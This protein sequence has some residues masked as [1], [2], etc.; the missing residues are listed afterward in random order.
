M[1]DYTVG[2]TIYHLFTTRQFSDGVPTVLAGSPVLSAY[3]DDSA[4]QITAGI[5]LGVSHDSV[6]GMNLITIVATG[7]NGYETGKNYNVVITTGTVGGVSVVGEVVWSFSLGRAAAFGRLGAPA[8]ASVSADIAVIEGQTDDIGIAGAGLTG[9]GGMS[10]AMKAEVN[11]EADTALTDYDGPTNA[12]MEARTLVAASYFDP[13]ADAVANVTLVG[14][15]TTN[16]DMVGTDGALLAANVNVAAGVVESNVKQISDDGTSPP[17]L[18]L[19]FDGTTGLTGSLFPSTQG[20]IGGIAVTGSANNKAFD[21]YVLTTGTQ[22][23]NTVAAVRPLDGTK[24]EHTDDAG[25]MDLYY[26]VNIGGGTP[27]GVKITGLLNSGNDDLEVYGYDWI[28]AAWVQI[29]ELEG[30]SSTSSNGINEYDLLLEMVG[31]GSDFGKVRVR[32]TDGAFTLTSATLRIDQLLCS[33]ASAQSGYENGAIWIDTNRS[34]TNTVPGIDGKATNPVS[35]M[36]AAN[37]LS[38]LL[39][40]NR[41]EIA[42][43]SSITFAATQSGQ[44]FTGEE[45]ALALGGQDLTDSHIFGA[46]ITGIAT[47]TNSMHFVKCNVGTATLDSCHIEDSG[48]AGTITLGEAGTYILNNCHS[49]V[50]GPSTP[51]IDTGAAISNVNLAMPDYHNGI[52]L[53]NLNATG[54]DLFSISGIGQIIYAASCSGAVEQRGEWKVTN[55]GGVTITTDDDSTNIAAILDDTADM[56]PKLGSPAV[57]ISADILAID[58][59]VD[60]IESTL[61]VAGAGLTDL[62]GMSTAMKAEIQVEADASLASYDGP[63]NAE[64]VARTLAAASYF[65]PAADAVANV[66]LVATTTVNTDMVGTDNA[67]LAASA[68]TNFGDLSISITTG[69]VDITQAAADKVWSTAVRILT[70][71]TNFNDVSAAEVNAEVDTALADIDL[72]HLLKT[73]TAIPALT[74]GTFLDQMLDDGT[75]TF[76]RTTDSLQA[77]RDRG[78]NAWITA[79]GFSSHTAADVWTVATRVLTANT[80]LNDISTADVADEL[81][82]Y[83]GPTNAEM[84]AR[85]LVAASYFDPTTDAVATVT[86]LTNKT[87]FSLAATGLDAIVSTATG[88]VAI[89]KAVWDRIISKANHDIGQSAGKI[90]RLSGNIAQVDGAVSDVSPAVGGFDTNLIYP[91]TYWEDAIL[92]FSNGAA[93]AG[94]G[95]PISTFLNANGAMTFA[96]PDDW[97]V[98][99]VNGDD[100]TIYGFHVHPVA[101]IADAV[102]EAAVTGR[103]AGSLGT[104]VADTETDATAILADTADMQPKL[105]TPATDLAADVAAVK[106]DTAAIL[107]DTAEIGVAGAGLTDLGGMSTGMKAEV[108]AEVVDVMTVDTIAEP[109][110]PPAAD[111]PAFDKLAWVT[112]LARNKKNGTATLKTLR[113]DD[114]NADIATAVVSDDGTTYTEDEWV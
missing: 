34:N 51:I 81:A 40:L 92:V 2:E 15:V 14:T 76:D 3:E 95:L 35:T 44:V 91:D 90:L 111:A 41:F 68:P 12:E 18:A 112:V 52:E 54:T 43:A 28:A 30:Q 99:P 9:L 94:L 42:P 109:S 33:F 17:N 32:F 62:G 98:T 87:G 29:G 48:F 56:Q 23:A 104:A 75:A 108:N 114:D 107:V 65:D 24:H 73:A 36:D 72:D 7:A 93:N 27:S 113:N 59:F 70:A 46:D 100:F 26:E 11:A 21:S 50:A 55:T 67:L 13:A 19:Q 77:I 4:T 85:T 57:D 60:G 39:N 110:G 47:N 106:V 102:L 103:S 20:Q 37:T 89:A 16:T 31:T 82:T 22:S 5:T 58:N 53:R 84:E 63:T 88:M 66:T 105:G 49:S 6:A 78:D 80:N 61:G 96:A 38:G 83:D 8:G 71:S 86:T 64:M 79:T 10:T 97:P 69:L 74:A 1:T 45:W 25:A 101:Q